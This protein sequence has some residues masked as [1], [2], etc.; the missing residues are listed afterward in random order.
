VFAVFV[1]VLVLGMVMNVGRQVDGKIR[2]QNA[3]DNAAFSG[4]LVIAR[5]LNTLA[6]TNHMMS[7]VFALTAFLREARDRNSESFAGP[8]LLAWSTMAP[9]LAGANVPKFRELSDAIPRKVELEHQMVTAYGDWAAAVVP[10]VLPVMEEI[11]RQEAIPQFQRSVVALYPHLAQAAAMEV[12]EQEGRPGNGR[13]TMVGVLWRTSGRIVGGESEARDPTLPVI[14]PRSDPVLRRRAREARDRLARHYLREWNDRAMH[15]FDRFA[16]MSQFA[17]LWRGFTCG[18]L[19]ELLSQNPNTNLPILLRDEAVTTTA[20]ANSNAYLDQYFT[21][22][23][24][25]YWGRLPGFAPWVFRNPLTDA[26]G[27]PADAAAFA[28]V[29][30]YIPRPRLMYWWTSPS[31]LDQS[32]GGVPGE[33][34]PMPPGRPLAGSNP[35]S[36]PIW[37]IRRQPG[38]TEEW[39]SFNQRWTAQLVPA[40]HES[41]AMILRTAPPVAEFQRQHFRVA[42]LGG[43]GTSD[44]ARVNTH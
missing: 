8:I 35:P 38:A 24:V 19:E 4:G 31:D 3:A 2:M 40:T 25:A 36:L 27:Q 20:R 15:G 42:S 39:S 6:F 22:I 12:A 37:R 7:E 32:V 30:V 26:A 43:L 28:Q 1:F 10:N 18:N 16:K 23:G 21:L 9:V 13:G 44:I 14:D 11:L 29:R 41:L 34:L 33:T 17:S 5:G